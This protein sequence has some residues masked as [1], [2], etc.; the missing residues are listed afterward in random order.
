[1]AGLR[2][3]V[4]VRQIAQLYGVRPGVA[5]TLILLRRV[6]WTAAGVSGMELLS[7]TLADHAL[8]EL[9]IVKRLVGAVPGS[10]LAAI[11]LYRLAD[12]TAEACSPLPSRPG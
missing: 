7:Q 10:G 11:R 1:M 2:G 5:A 6:A 12:M 8:K 9:P 3:L 4:L